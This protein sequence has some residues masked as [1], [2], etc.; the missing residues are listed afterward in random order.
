MSKVRVRFAPSPTGY[1]HVGAART[2]FY[3]WLF[4]RHFNGDFVLRI[5]DT[6]MERSSR[7]MSRAIL[8]GLQW[9]G[10][11]W[12]EG[13]VY[14][15]ERL[16]VYRN[17]TE[18][19]VRSGRA[20]PCFCDP[21]EIK[22]RKKSG[23]KNEG[24]WGYDCS[25]RNLSPEVRKR[26]VKEGK[27]RAVRFKV[28]GKHVSYHDM[29]HGPISV[30]TKEIEDFVLLRSDGLPTYH[31]SVVVDDI[32]QKISHVI[33][34]DDHISNTP[35]QILLYEAFGVSPP[36][37]AHQALILGPDRKKLSKRHGVTSVLTFREQGYLPSSLINFFARM[38]WL[39]GDE[40]KIFSLE[41]LQKSFSMEKL[42]KSSPVFDPQKLKWLNGLVMAQ[43]S[44]GDLLPLVK[45]SFKKA[46]VLE[47]AWDT[48]REKIR[49]LKL[50]DLY[51]TR[52]K[53]AAEIAMGL[54]PFFMP[55][56]SYDPEGVE[57]HLSDER[58]P[59]LIK[60][61]KD[62][63]KRLDGFKA[64]DTERVLR[65]RA[66]KEGVKAGLLIHAVRLLV[67]GKTQSPGIFDVLELL[68]KEKTLSRLDVSRFLS[69]LS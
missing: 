8:E 1:L 62:D 53:T 42:S 6:D 61:L 20:Y 64:S 13:P 38:N 23:G 69:K 36:R 26:Y 67:L 44:A 31:L 2:A 3:N 27:P 9:L 41:E 14:Q 37:F 57:K 16:D 48:G 18:E 34:G 60:K 25:C 51:K 4:A 10:L 46:G 50:I 19:L 17:K 66:E 30:N 21:E 63:F 68:G 40:E 65:D 15:S 54:E 11:N 52:C 22:R 39:P 29:L 45:K 12:D 7:E 56:I 49:L 24:T 5:E 47:P 28:E 55:E 32:L 58:L 33:R 35:K 59:A 43:T